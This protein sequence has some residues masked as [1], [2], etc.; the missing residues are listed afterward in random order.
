[1]Q[2]AAY[3]RPT[4]HQRLA[5]PHPR[6]RGFVRAPSGNGYYHPRTHVAQLA[7]PSPVW[8][9]RRIA[10]PDRGRRDP[11]HQVRT[12]RAFPTS[13]PVDEPSP[14][15]AHTFSRSPPRA[16]HESSF[17][18]RTPGK[19]SARRPP[20]IRITHTIARPT[21]RAARAGHSLA[22]VPASAH[23]GWA[24]GHRSPSA[25]RCRSAEIWHGARARRGTHVV[26]RTRRRRESTEDRLPGT[27]H[28]ARP[29]SRTRFVSRG[30]MAHCLHPDRP[31]LAR[32]RGRRANTG[33]LGGVTLPSRVTMDDGARPRRHIAYRI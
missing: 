6:R 24:A 12:Y 22:A 7:A 2:H 1:M 32:A 10:I 30:A 17:P 23:D 15:P 11:T 5:S 25:A 26:H 20:P 14:L 8:T 13:N 19:P 9:R 4:R 33:V 3:V 29:C 16:A 31:K 28:D 18:P 27:H 21:P